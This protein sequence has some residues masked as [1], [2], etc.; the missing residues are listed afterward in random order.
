MNDS[1][2][3]IVY[4]HKYIGFSVG[5]FMFASSFGKFHDVDFTMYRK[6]FY[7]AQGQQTMKKVICGQ[8]QSM[9]YFDRAIEYRSLLSRF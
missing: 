3:P 7:K 1:L 4:N 2:G 9:F 8:I 5:I 6:L